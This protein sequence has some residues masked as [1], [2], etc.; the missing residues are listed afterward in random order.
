MQ[1]V[2]KIL[3]VHCQ[4]CVAGSQY[5]SLFQQKD[6]L[7]FGILL[8]ITQCL[9]LTDAFP[10]FGTGIPGRDETVGGQKGIGRKNL[11]LLFPVCFLM[12]ERLP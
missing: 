8:L 11:L 10:G 9:Q 4:P 3:A 5:L 7:L 1:L 2:L 6:F 12:Y